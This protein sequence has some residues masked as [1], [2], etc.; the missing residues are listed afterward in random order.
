M[1]VADRSTTSGPA[2]G[3]TSRP[4]ACRP[5]SEMRCASTSC[6]SCA[7]L[8]RSASRAWSARRASAVSACSARARSDATRSRRA[9]RKAPTA[10]ARPRTSRFEM[11]RP[12]RFPAPES[13]EVSQPR[14]G[15]RPER[16]VAA[17]DRR[18]PGA[19]GAGRRGR[20]RARS[21]CRGPRR[22]AAPAVATAARRHRRCTPR[23]SAPPG[24]RAPSNGARDLRD[25]D[26]GGD[27]EV[28]RVGRAGPHAGAAPPGRR[29]RCRGRAHGR[30]A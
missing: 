23:R 21:G 3:R 13:S 26:E 7:I 14:D 25:R 11:P 19:T 5:I 12:A 20:R 1:S 8:V 27:R 22:G 18:G 9:P 2:S 6:I 15:H 28:E 29:R 30:R 10:I 4:P 16:P 17:A 24:R